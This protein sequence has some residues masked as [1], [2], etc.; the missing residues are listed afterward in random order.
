MQ[1]CLHCDVANQRHFQAVRILRVIKNVKCYP[2]GGV[3]DPSPG[4]V[5]LPLSPSESPIS[6]DYSQT[7]VS[8]LLVE[9]AVYRTN[10]A[11]IPIC[12]I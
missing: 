5:R 12:V 10:L 6:H 9:Y 7:A 1:V 4:C 11:F 3:V 2:E 8:L